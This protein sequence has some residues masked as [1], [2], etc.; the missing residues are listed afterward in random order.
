MLEIT[1]IMD[2]NTFIMREDQ[3]IEMLII[4]GTILMVALASSFITWVVIRKGLK[5]PMKTPS[6]PPLMGTS[7]ENGV[8]DCAQKYAEI[9]EA[10]KKLGIDEHHPYLLECQNRREEMEKLKELMGRRSELIPN[11]NNYFYYVM[12]EYMSQLMGVGGNSL[13]KD[14]EE[15]RIWVDYKAVYESIK[16]YHDKVLGKK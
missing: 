5:N 8:L 15:Y 2:Y 9:V 11:L 12:V 4:L 6:S 16:K 1:T 3:R 10:I 14:E 7:R 13:H